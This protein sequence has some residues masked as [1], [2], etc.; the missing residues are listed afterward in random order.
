MSFTLL[1]N[2]IIKY[3]LA[4]GFHSYPRDFNLKSQARAELYYYNELDKITQEEN[5]PKNNSRRQD[6]PGYNIL[7][8]RII[9]YVKLMLQVHLT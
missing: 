6:I 5:I 2:R 3:K 7:K 1:I 9:I 4:T 8:R